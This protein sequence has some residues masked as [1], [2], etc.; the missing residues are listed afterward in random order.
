MGVAYGSRQCVSWISRFGCLGGARR[1]RAS[2][3]GPALHS[4]A[5]E[6]FVQWK[7]L[8]DRQAM[9]L[10]ELLLLQ[11]WLLRFAHKRDQ[12]VAE[13][14]SLKKCGAHLRSGAIDGLQLSWWQLCSKSTGRAQ[15]HC[16]PPAH[17][18]S[19]P[20]LKTTEKVSSPWGSGFSF[21]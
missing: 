1:Q 11:D 8:P 5:E 2:A 21:F 4:S 14:Q 20:S 13:L 19:F 3:S 17:L 9:Q 15:D 18:S 12:Q 16:S 10:R 7:P 6:P